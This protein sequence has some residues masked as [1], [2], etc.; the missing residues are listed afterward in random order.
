MLGNEGGEQFFRPD[1]GLFDA[2]VP[3]QLK[4]CDPGEGVPTGNELP[5]DLRLPS[6]H[7]LFEKLCRHGVEVVGPKP[8]GGQGVRIPHE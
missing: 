6:A 5:V 8:F 7:S 2:Q 3:F 4:Q 1:T